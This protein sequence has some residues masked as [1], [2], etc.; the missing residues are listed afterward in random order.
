MYDNIRPLEKTMKH[1]YLVLIIISI[2]CVSI[3]CRN[4]AKKEANYKSTAETVAE[5]ANVE[6]IENNTDFDKDSLKYKELLPIL[7]PGMFRSPSFFDD[8]S[9]LEN[10]IKYYRLALDFYNQ[11]KY[12]KA[13]DNYA[14]ACQDYNCFGI[15]YYQLGLC[16]MDAGDYGAAKLSFNRAANYSDTM[17]L[18][19]LYSIDANG[20]RR[21][22]YFSYYNIACIESLRNNTEVA[23]EYLCKALYH[24]Y[25]YLDHLKKDADLRN[26]F[27]YNNGSFLKSI[28]EI[29]NAGSNNM[30]MGKGYDW[31]GGNAS[32]DY[33]FID[34]NHMMAMFWSVWPDPGGWITAEYEIKNYIIIVKN[35]KYHYEEE[36]RFKLKR[37]ILYITNFVSLDGNEIYYKEVSP[38]KDFYNDLLLGK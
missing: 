27:S 15:V 33:Y 37:F 9:L 7:E 36:E 4:T 18:N 25:P 28:E 13:I 21:E 1:T 10:S 16:L 3:S 23:Y 11:K 32:A 29:Y 34:D 20:L 38:D 14:L 17:W 26:L 35:I 19:E 12:E 30:I 8:S 24:G 6:Y 22:T 2:V 31:Q 5:T